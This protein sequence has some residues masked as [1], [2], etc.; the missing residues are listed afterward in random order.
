MVFQRNPLTSGNGDSR[1]HKSPT[2]PYQRILLV[3]P[4][5]DAIGA[6]F[7]MEDVP[8]RLEYLAAYV[9]PHVEAVEVADLIKEGKPLSY[10]LEHFQPDLVGVT[11]NYISTHRTSLLLAEEAKQYGAD[12][13]FGGYLATALDK[14]FALDPNVDYVVRGEGEQTLLELIER[15]PLDEVLGITFA[16]DGE[17]VET[18]HRPNIEDLD[19]L[20]F[21]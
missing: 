20:P 3:N 2:A 17:V 8:L 9:R 13:V 4:C 5:M 7:M 11:L 1:I 21:P 10:Y 16:R 15:R 14:D 19:Q 6:E 18:G 12:V